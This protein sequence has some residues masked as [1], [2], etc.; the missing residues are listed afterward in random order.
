M[1]DALVDIADHNIAPG[2]A[3]DPSRL[4]FPPPLEHPTSC[5]LISSTS[6]TRYRQQLETEEPAFVNGAVNHISVVCDS[7]NSSFKTRFP[8]NQWL[9][10]FQARVWCQWSSEVFLDPKGAVFRL[11]KY[12]HSCSNG[13]NVR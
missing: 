6:Y 9:L 3:S 1:R 11:E 4:S 12:F 8:R 7:G 10:Q 13:D 2:A 5:D